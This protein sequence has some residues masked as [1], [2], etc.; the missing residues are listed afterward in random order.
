[1]N[2]KIPNCNTVMLCTATAKQPMKNKCFCRNLGRL[3]EINES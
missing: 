3:E 2:I 1:M